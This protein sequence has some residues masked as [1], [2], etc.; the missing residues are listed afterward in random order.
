MTSGSLLKAVSSKDEYPGLNC[1]LRHIGA[2][3]LIL[4]L[5][6]HSALSMQILHLYGLSRCLMPLLL[7]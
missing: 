3:F 1:N 6:V 4:L 2:Y 5:P 7:W